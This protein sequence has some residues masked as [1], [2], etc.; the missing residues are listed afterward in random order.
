MSTAL[1]RVAVLP[2]F[3]TLIFP[4]FVL[5]ASEIVVSPVRLQIDHGKNTAALNLLN[6]SEKRVI[7]QL[8]SFLWS[9]NQGADQ[10]AATNDILATPPIFAVE[11]GKSQVI[12]VILRGS[13]P[14]LQE[15]TYRI[16]ITEVPDEAT[17]V[18]GQVR[19]NLRMSIPVFV[20]PGVPSKPQIVCSLH[21]ISEKNLRLSV[22]NTGNSHILL[23]TLKLFP[24]QEQENP[25]HQ[26]L[27]SGYVL[28]GQSRSWSL[29]LAQPFSGSNAYL[30]ADTD[31]GEKAVLLAIQ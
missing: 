15:I 24:N 17:R 28:P 20:K 26:I 3:F 19:V 31:D 6:K 25:F 22:N 1:L 12:R 9:Q 30:R 27:L 18:I 7:F 10:L 4:L 2:S 5:E 16:L 21:K 8:E 29:D 13:K 11:P 23:G 14:Q